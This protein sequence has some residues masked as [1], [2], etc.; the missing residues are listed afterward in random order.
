MMKTTLDIPDKLLFQVKAQAALAGQSM[1]VFFIDA[2]RQRLAQMK[3]GQGNRPAPAW[4]KF[5]GVVPEKV[6]REIDATVE[7]GCEQ[8][9]PG[10]WA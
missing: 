7:S 6:A 4:K 2:V 5:V 10:D 8:V 9:D 1:R 3:R